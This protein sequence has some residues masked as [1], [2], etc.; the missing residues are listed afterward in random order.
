MENN[1]ELKEIKIKNF[2]CYYF[3]NTMGVRDFDFD[4]I[5]LDEKWIGNS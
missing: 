1:N 5:L 2:T 4:N 3:G